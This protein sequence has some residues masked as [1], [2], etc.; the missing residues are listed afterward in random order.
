MPSPD[1]LAAIAAVV[2]MALLVLS[3]RLV[4]PPG[5]SRPRHGAAWLDA[6]EVPATARYGPYNDERATAPMSAVVTIPD[7]TPFVRAA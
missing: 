3:M 4:R 5:S 6:H 1:T 2:F 7:P